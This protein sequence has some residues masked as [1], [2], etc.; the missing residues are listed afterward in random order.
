LIERLSRIQRAIGDSETPGDTESQARERVQDVLDGPRP[1]T[2]TMPADLFLSTQA[3]MLCWS[4]RERAE[5]LV[6]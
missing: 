6:G 5:K 1:S 3:E 2:K 4:S